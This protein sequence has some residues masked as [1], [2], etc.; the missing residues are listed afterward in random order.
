M[1]DMI[2][3][4]GMVDMIQDQDLT[5]SNCL[6]DM[7]NQ[8]D[9]IYHDHRIFLNCQILLDVFAVNVIDVIRT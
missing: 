8:C 4:Q 6:E 9:V 3:D 1:V 7:K 2:Q 5:D